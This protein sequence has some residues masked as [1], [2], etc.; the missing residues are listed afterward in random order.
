MQ[1]SHLRTSGYKADL[2]NKI[3]IPFQYSHAVCVGEPF[4][5]LPFNLVKQVMWSS[6]AKQDRWLVDCRAA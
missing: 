6:C 2:K 5:D 3:R 4:K 1:S